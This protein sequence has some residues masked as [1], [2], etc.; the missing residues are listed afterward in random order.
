MHEED[1][2]ME[3]SED[4]YDKDKDRNIVSNSFKVFRKYIADSIK[5]KNSKLHR[6]IELKCIGYSTSDFS[7]DFERKI[8][9]DRN[10]FG[11]KFLR[12]LL[13]KK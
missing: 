4:L 13:N 10:Y 1:D 6:I 12:A 5:I 9:K 11:I 3:G 7:K 8:P 2:L